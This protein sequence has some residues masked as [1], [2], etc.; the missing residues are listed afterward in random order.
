MRDARGKPE[1][2]G[3]VGT[4]AYTSVSAA[5]VPTPVGWQRGPQA[6]PHAGGPH[7]FPPGS[8]SRIW[9]GQGRAQHRA[10]ATASSPSVTRHDRVARH[11]DRRDGG[12][13]IAHRSD[14]AASNR[15]EMRPAINNRRGCRV[16]LPQPTGPRGT[17]VAVIPLSVA[18]MTQGVGPRRSYKPLPELREMVFKQRKRHSFCARLF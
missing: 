5:L 15:E 18:R 7:N 3:S 11:R 6:S 8:T 1:R 17:C 16:R 12:N 14:C 9:P 13:S 4:S 2:G 10:D